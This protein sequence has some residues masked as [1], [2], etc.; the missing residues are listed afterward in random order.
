VNLANFIT[1]IRLLL[2]V[3][4]VYFLYNEEIFLSIILFLFFLSLD[5][6]DGFVARKLKCETVFGKN[7]DFITDGLVGSFIVLVLL[8]QHKIP[9]LYICLFIPPLVLLTIAVIWGIK[10]QKNT[11]IPAKWRKWNGATLFLTVL[12]FM[13]NNEITIILAYVILIYIYVSRIKHLIELGKK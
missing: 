13:I 6:L 1:L 3:P 7:F 2:G 9:L 5:I 8:Q 11:F 12:L 10:K 4:I